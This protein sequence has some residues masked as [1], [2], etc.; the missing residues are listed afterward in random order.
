M[1]SKDI[2]S[3]IVKQSME[4]VDVNIN[5]M[6]EN[7][8]IIASGDKNRINTIHEGALLAIKRKEFVSIKGADVKKLRGTKEGVNLP[9]FRR[10]VLQGVIGISGDCDEILKHAQLLK[11]TTE[12]FL[13]KELL[14]E[15][16]IKHKKLKNNFFLAVIKNDI[17]LF[18]LDIISLYS[19][20]LLLSH[21]HN[22]IIIKFFDEDFI[23]LNSKLVTAFKIVNNLDIKFSVLLDG[24]EI[25]FVISNRSKSKLSKKR[26]DILELIDKNLEKNKISNYKM[27]VGCIF[28]EQIGINESYRTAVNLMNNKLINNTN[29]FFA[30]EYLLETVINS[31]EES[32]ETNHFVNLWGE[33]VK[34]DK[35]N[36]L[37]DTIDAYYELNC[38][39]KKV[40]EKLNIHRN[41]LKYRFKKI[42]NI[43]GLNPKNKKSL[44]TLIV[45]KQL[46]YRQI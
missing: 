26:L 14:I 25:A 28:K 45:A 33:L 40:S 4:I 38:E 27:Y 11:M 20:K 18:N 1:I 5:I 16:Q 34:E 10:G 24:N 13:E 9:L 35:Y 43:T 21:Y 30:E 15:E 31:T 42:E 12:L 22:V 3:Q 7:G 23:E 19:E 46:Y 37:T 36:E 2:A 17:K 8:I 39:N 41:T 32:L 44:F 29:T 6:D